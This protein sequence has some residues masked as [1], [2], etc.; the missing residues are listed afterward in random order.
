MLEANLD[1]PILQVQCTKGLINPEVMP[2]NKK[3][4]NT[5]LESD[6]ALAILHSR[7]L[8]IAAIVTD[9]D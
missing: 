5:Y 6:V 8:V 4:T 3:D 9:G 1:L 7:R 2:R